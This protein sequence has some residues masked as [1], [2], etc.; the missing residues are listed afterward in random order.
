ML[1]SLSETCLLDYR[2]T[3]SEPALLAY[4]EQTHYWASN[5]WNGHKEN[6]FFEYSDYYQWPSYIKTGVQWTCY[7]GI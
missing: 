3:F 6:A 4:N 1:K 7:N 2:T 5:C